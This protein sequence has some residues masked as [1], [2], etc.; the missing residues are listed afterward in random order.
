MKF[1]TL[2]ILLCISLPGFSDNSPTKQALP[3]RLYANINHTFDVI[4]IEPKTTTLLATNKYKTV[5]SYQ[6]VDGK[7]L[8]VAQNNENKW[9][10]IDPQGNWVTQPIFEKAKAFSSDNIARVQKDEKW[11]FIKNDGSFLIE[12]KYYNVRPFRQGLSAVQETENGQVYYINLKDEKVFEHSFSDARDFSDNGLAAV[13][14]SDSIPVFEI[15]ADKVIKKGSSSGNKQWGYINIKGEV[16]IEPQFKHASRFNQFNIARV[17]DK[18]DDYIIIDAKGK[19]VTETRFEYLWGF[20]ESGVAW[21]ESKGSDEFQGYIDTQGQHVWK[22]SYHNFNNEKNGLLVNVRGDYQFYDPFG[23]LVLKEESTWADSFHDAEATIALRDKQWGILYRDDTFKKFPENVVAP[24]TTTNSAV[25]GF[26]DGLIAMITTE[27][28][29]DYFDKQGQL[30]YSIK[31]SNNGLMSLFNNK[32][33]LLWESTHKARP[34]YAILSPG[35]PEHFNDI[36]NHGQ[37]IYKTIEE[38]LT[39]EPKQ[40]FI[41]N[42][43]FSSSGTDPYKIEN[44]DNDEEIKIGS[45]NIIAETYTSEEEWGTYEFLDA[46][47]STAFSRYLQT[48]KA[49]ITQKYGDPY[50]TKYGKN[51]WQISDQYLTLE[52]LSGSG[53]GDYYHQLTLEV[54]KVKPHD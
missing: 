17:R 33:T 29:V 51:I 4:L 5:H 15:Y 28:S 12:P 54:N 21:S 52:E 14:I 11:G 25:L 47:D 40:Y 35:L 7:A 53:D 13:E 20:S 45:I 39:I 27:R 46:H 36:T 34:V 26:I 18:H 19:L 23:K 2:L 50:H 9:G 3:T 1:L 44:N 43:L 48:L 8:A 42:P 6:I 32:D 41:P 30:Q 10:Y 31:P 16:I 38:L 37:G 49:L 24:L 22:E